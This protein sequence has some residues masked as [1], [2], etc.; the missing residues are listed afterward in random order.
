MWQLHAI[1]LLVLMVVSAGLLVVFHNSTTVIGGG[2]QAKSIK[3]N[4][5]GAIRV[6]LGGWHF[7]YP[8]EEILH[9]D[10]DLNLETWELDRAHNNALRVTARDGTAVLLEVG[11]KAATG[12]KCTPNG[13]PIGRHEIDVVAVWRAA[14]LTEPDKESRRRYIRELFGVFDRILGHYRLEQI[15]RPQELPA[16]QQPMVPP[17]VVV[18]RADET[19]EELRLVPKRAPNKEIFL[20]EIGRWAEALLNFE[21]RDGG[22]TVH[23][24]TIN[25]VLAEDEEARNA[26]RQ[27]TINRL[28]TEALVELPDEIPLEMQY[29]VGGD[30]KA[31]AWGA[32][33][34]ALRKFVDVVPAL[35]DRIAQAISGPRP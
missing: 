6:I 30:D 1:A 27:R 13:Q 23:E 34:A 20:A 31:L 17:A 21:L 29:L 5:T 22:F 26:I 33:A 12:R 18:L 2:R 4:L 7:Y 16:D 11:L 10:I 3:N 25:D 15:T 35:V 24:V 9:Q 19:H 28:R 32:T 8:W 14:T